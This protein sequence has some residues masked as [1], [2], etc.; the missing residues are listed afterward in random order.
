MDDAST[1]DEDEDVCKEMQKLKD[2]I[3]VGKALQELARWVQKWIAK[4]YPTLNLSVNLKKEE[5]TKEDTIVF[6]YRECH[7]LYSNASNLKRHEAFFKTFMH[8]WCLQHAI[9]PTAEKVAVT[10]GA[11]GGS[12]GWVTEEVTYTLKEHKGEVKAV[13][14]RIV[15]AVQQL[16]KELTAEL[17]ANNPKSLAYFVVDPQGITLR[18]KHQGERDSH[19]ETVTPQATQDLLRFVGNPAKNLALLPTPGKK[20]P[21]TQARLAAAAAAPALAILAPDA[22]P[23]PA[24]QGGDVMEGI[25]DEFD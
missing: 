17:D 13:T 24:P 8:L 7:S 4:A 14:V 5:Y 2:A 3:K 21:A 11:G 10:P 16:I 12:M 19:R 15:A 9:I 23:P 25:V 18:L 22:A 1:E 6:V 20:S